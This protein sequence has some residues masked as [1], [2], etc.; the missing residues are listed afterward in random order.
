MKQKC[1][2]T[3]KIFNF[4]YY[5]KYIANSNIVPKNIRY[6]TNGVNEYLFIHT[7]IKFIDTIE[8]T[9]DKI[10]AVIRYKFNL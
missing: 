2:S 4:I 1:Q 3:W 10:V 5:Q 7:I 6:I 9:N 8:K